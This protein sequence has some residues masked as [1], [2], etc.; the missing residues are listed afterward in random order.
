MFNICQKTMLYSDL[1]VSV[2][3]SCAVPFHQYRKPH[4]VCLSALMLEQQLTLLM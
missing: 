1:A 3:L 4:K 2:D